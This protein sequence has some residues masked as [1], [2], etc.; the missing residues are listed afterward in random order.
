[1][2]NLNGKVS[3]VVPAYNEGS[4]ICANLQEIAQTFDDFG[5][6]YEIILIDDGSTDNTLEEALKAAHKTAHIRVKRNLKNYGKGRALKKSI[7]Y[8]TGKYVVFIDADLDLH[9]GQIQ[10]FFDIM[11][12]DDVDVVIGSKLHPNSK[13]EYPVSRR[14]ISIIYYFCIKLL[15]GLPIHDTQT[16]LKVFKLEVL[17]KV[18]P[19][20][21]EKKFALDLEILANVHRLGFKIIEAPVVLTQKRPYGRIGVKAIWQTGIDTMAIFYRMYIMRY[22][23][24]ILTEEKPQ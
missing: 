4:T 2:K 24:Q 21:L 3:V 6:E 14:V 17:R 9:P 19:K 15:F 22:Y 10:T 1:M 16:G 5:C 20:I 7:R 12:L 11:R 18:M 8:V 13:V 23:D